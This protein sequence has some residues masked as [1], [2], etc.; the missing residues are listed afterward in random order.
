MNVLNKFIKQDVVYKDIKLTDDEFFN[1][2]HTFKME[3]IMNLLE[4]GEDFNRV[5]VLRRLVRIRCMDGDLDVGL[6]YYMIY[7]VSEIDNQVL[8]DYLNVYHKTSSFIFFAFIRRGY[9]LEKIGKYTGFDR[10][11]LTVASEIRFSKEEEFKR[12]ISLIDEKFIKYCIENVES[13]SEH[14][15]GIYL[16]TITD[17]N[18]NEDEFNMF[19]EKI[20]DIEYAK[21]DDMRLYMNNELLIKLMTKVYTKFK[22][23][24]YHVV[25]NNEQAYNLMKIGFDLPFNIVQQLLS[26]VSCMKHIDVFSNETIIK[27]LDFSRD[28]NINLLVNLNNDELRKVLDNCLR[29]YSCIDNKPLDNKFIEYCVDRIKNYSSNFYIKQFKYEDFMLLVKLDIDLTARNMTLDNIFHFQK[30]YRIAVYVI[31]NKLYTGKFNENGV[32]DLGHLSSL[33]YKRMKDKDEYKR[34]LTNF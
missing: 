28:M 34:Y 10:Y 21:I 27:Y 20:Q 6:L 14:V 2:I 19:L 13:I 1:R 33:I 30:D 26:D 31:D 23:I 25:L 15:I 18:Y 29:N 8:Y 12:K 4:I 7:F 11:L 9:R 16:T 17:E 32:S 24:D 22:Q 5:N 3:N